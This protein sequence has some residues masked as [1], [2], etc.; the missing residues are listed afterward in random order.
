MPYF[1]VD[2]DTSFNSNCGDSYSV[3]SNELKVGYS[4][5]PTGVI[6]Q[7]GAR[8]ASASS[9]SSPTGEGA[10]MLVGAGSRQSIDWNGTE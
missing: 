6:Q 10:R 9:N 4:T 2:N 8:L 3:R 1:F 5:E 7:I